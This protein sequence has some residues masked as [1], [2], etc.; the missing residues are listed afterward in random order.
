MKRGFVVAL[1]LLGLVASACS[2]G[3][4]A[5]APAT[6]S[7][8]PATETS[9]A[10]EA[11]ETTAAVE[12]PA[13][14]ELA[15]LEFL[16]FLDRSYGMLAVRT[17]QALTSAGV[18]HL[19]GL[20][21][22][23]LDDLS[24]AFL[25]ETRALEVQI[26]EL[27]DGYDRTALTPD[28]QEFRDLYAWYLDQLI[29]GHPFAYHDYPVHPIVNSYNV[30]LILML[31]GE[32]PMNTLE[33]AEDYITRLGQIDTQVDQLIEGLEIRRDLGNVP[34]RNILGMTLER[35][36]GEISG[37][38]NR[39]ELYTSFEERL[40]GV[41]GLDEATRQSLLDAALT[42]V[43]SSFVP[44][45]EALIAHLESI[46]PLA[47]TDPGVWRLPDGEAYYQYLLRDQTTTD[48]SA[49][50]IHAMGVEHVERVQ[51]ELRAIFD[52]LGYPADSSISDLLARAQTDGGSMNG[53][54]R[55]GQEEV[56]RRYESLIAAADDAVGPLFTARPD[57]DVIVIPEP[58][59]GGGFYVPSSADGS[60]PGAFHAGVGGNNIPRYIMPTIAFHEAV[61][62]HHFQIAL[63]QELDLPA[64]QR[65]T[66]YNGFVEG[67]ALYAERLAAEMGLYV[68]DPFG[69]IGRLELELLRAVRLVV[70]TGI[71]D[72]GWS[73]DEARA[74]FSDTLPRWSH[75]VERY[76]VMPGQATGYMVGQ[77][78]ILELRDE[79]LAALGDEFDIAAFHEIVIGGGSLPLDVLE[80]RVGVW[81]KAQ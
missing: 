16:D 59:G 31:T 36:R 35:L 27:L 72:L 65:F 49:E 81:I 21:N 20:R 9:V 68:G 3:G 28:Q 5:D 2:N 54:T 38:P 1:L 53:S 45:W 4:D 66:H 74:Y 80:E 44:A 22:D 7:T 58:L 52:A 78:R 24:P 77:Q 48:L 79:A 70:D 64:F 37:S 57:A 13:T 41:A 17:P 43:E 19:F 33:D 12:D 76:T 29:S 10:P 23:R 15:G 60:R 56:V 73:A 39:L 40:D 11:T 25:E 55:A 69:D 32:H 47:G 51:S 30:N 75:E 42:E 34:P 62:G 67:W 71:H 46:R 6:T 8:V 18:S 50:E 63:A 14:A 61:P 26:R